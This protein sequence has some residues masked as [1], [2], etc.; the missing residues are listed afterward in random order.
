MKPIERFQALIDGKRLRQANWPKN[1]FWEKINDVVMLLKKGSKSAYT[2]DEWTYELCGE[3]D[4]Y[5]ALFHEDI[6][7]EFYEWSK[8]EIKLTPE[9]V[10]RRVKLRNGD[11]LILSE[12]DRAHNVFRGGSRTWLSCGKFWRFGFSN[13]VDDSEFDIVEILPPNS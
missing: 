5:I 4:T 10:G 7:W 6:E 3:I 2:K 1:E 12:F 9:M 11:L 8:P 13:F